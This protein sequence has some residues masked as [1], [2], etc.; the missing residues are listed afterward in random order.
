M[1]AQA[2]IPAPQYVTLTCDVCFLKGGG[3]LGHYDLI[4]CSCGKIYWALRPAEGGQLVA[5]FEFREAP[6]QNQPKRRSKTNDPIGK[7]S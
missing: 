4:R 3:Y 2:S 5:L 7:Q 1:S 6:I